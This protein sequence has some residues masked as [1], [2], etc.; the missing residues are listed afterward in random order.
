MHNRNP[1]NS[2]KKPYTHL[3]KI[4]EINDGDEDYDNDQNTEKFQNKQ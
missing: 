1:K 2:K 4:N 3:Y